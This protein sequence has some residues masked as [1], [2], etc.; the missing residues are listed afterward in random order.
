MSLEPSE[1]EVGRVRV[2]GT[3]QDGKVQVT[4]EEVKEA[5]ESCKVE[6]NTWRDNTGKISIGV[7]ASLAGARSELYELG[8]QVRRFCVE[9]FREWHTI[10]QKANQEILK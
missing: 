2:E 7:R 9:H 1:L 6:V 4:S 8:D 5:G 3:V 10:V